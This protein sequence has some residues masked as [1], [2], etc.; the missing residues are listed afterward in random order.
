MAQRP[1]LLPGQLTL[2]EAAAGDATLTALV[3]ATVVTALTVGPSLYLLFRLVLTG[4]LDTEFHPILP[5]SG[6]RGHDRSTLLVAAA[7]ALRASG[8]A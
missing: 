1:D 7:V 2:A 8:S 4:R 6:S 5:A 3:V